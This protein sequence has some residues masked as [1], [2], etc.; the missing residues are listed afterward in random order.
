[1]GQT[2]L[3]ALLDEVRPRRVLFTTF[4]FS[5]GW[6]EAFCLPVL[7][8]SGCESVEV[9]I[10]S[11]QACRST[12]ESGSLYAGNAYRIVPVFMKSGGFFHPKLAYMEREDGG[13]VLV[14]GS[15]NL[16]FAGQAQ[17]LEVVDAV[18]SLEHPLVFQQFADFMA[19]F[20][21]RE[22]LTGETR[23][24]LG[25]YARRARVAASSGSP[26]AR[27]NQSVWL[28]HTLTEPVANQFSTRCADLGAVHQ[29]TVLAPYPQ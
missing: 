21:A 14:V 12:D 6:F 8:L 22:G 3:M 23:E 26:E 17:N 11:R 25:G 16:T 4:T 10:D 15:G 27:A 19:A 5:P 28:V 7:R 2:R 24:L 1:M 9:L 13:D 18:N 29:L 20:A